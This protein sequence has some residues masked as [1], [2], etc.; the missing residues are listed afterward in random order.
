MIAEI[1]EDFIKK[2]ALVALLGSASFGMCLTLSAI[3]IH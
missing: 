1:A 2:I 3:F